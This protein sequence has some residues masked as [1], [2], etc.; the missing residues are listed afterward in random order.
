[1]ARSGTR[2]L[3]LISSSI[4]RHILREL[5][6]GP[7]R[8]DEMWGLSGS[9]VGTGMPD[10]DAVETKITPAGEE[11]LFVAF[12]LERWLQNAP[13]GPLPFGESE[14]KAVIGALKGGWTSTVLH[15]LAAEPRTQTELDRATG[16][17]NSRSLEFHLKEM[18]RAELV[19]ARPSDGEGAIYAVTDWLRE[20]IAPLAVAARWERHHA[21]AE[22]APIA[23]L[24]VEAAF[25]L[26]VPMLELPAELSGSCRLVVEIDNVGEHRQAGVTVWVEDGQVASCA[27]DLQA[28][29]DAFAI[30]PASAWLDAV[31]EAD[32][33]DIRLGGDRELARALLT[34]LHVTL[35]GIR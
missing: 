34:E 31:I 13:K 28:E 1:V 10:P 2:G 5:S 23:G 8:L 29:A 14:A 15:G 3:S 35:F 32:T 22:T 4:S 21:A 17:L 20:G 24:D 18:Q 19:A 12:I 26:T 33:H 27:V 9:P 7:K 11:L 6:E 30:G 25:L 16:A